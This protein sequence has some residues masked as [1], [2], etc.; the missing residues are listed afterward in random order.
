MPTLLLVDD[1]RDG[2]PIRR[3][4]FERAGFEVAAATTVN[5]ARA[6][7]FAHPAQIVLLDLHLPE[8]EDGCALIRDFRAHLPGVRLVVLSGFAGDI[9]QRPESHMIDLILEKPLRS[10]KLV[11]AVAGTLD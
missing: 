5:E 10:E 6:A 8:L 2:L 11:R 7:F 3:L 9:H 1:D 4:I